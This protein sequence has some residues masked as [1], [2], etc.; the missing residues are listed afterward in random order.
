MPCSRGAAS[1]GAFRIV[2]RK[3]PAGPV[4]DVTLS[5]HLRADVARL[6]FAP[7]TSMFWYG[8]G[9]RAAAVDWRPEV[10]D[11]DGLALFTGTGERIWRPLLNPPQPVTNSFADKDPRGF[12]LLQRD[13]RFANYQ[14][15][16]AFYEKRP[17]LWVE[18]RG[19]WQA[20]S[21]ML[22]E[23]PT[24]KEIEDNIVAF[25]VPAVPARRGASYDLEYRLNWT[26]GDQVP[27]SLARVV[28]AW[29]GTAGSP[30]HEPT[31][32]ARRLVADF[33]GPNLAGLTRDSGVEAVVSAAGGKLLASH[34]YP[35][36]GTASRWRLIAELAQGNR[37]PG[38]IRAYLKNGTNA[39]S[40][41]LLYDLY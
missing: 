32:G 28:D 10:H 29:T 12:G 21:V 31:P 7:L 19:A 18:P 20:G 22:C 6:G 40:E 17:N 9:N 35:V 37:G 5:V 14:D 36:V 3:S 39:L 41:T 33:A 38:N 30:G 2:S 4:Q 11:S 13:R 1:P 24:R 16:G 15:D 27:Q 25:W 26:A 8:E 34:A 23:I